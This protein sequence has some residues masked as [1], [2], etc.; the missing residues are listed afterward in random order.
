MNKNSIKILPV[1][2]GVI[3]VTGILYPAISVSAAASFN[4]DPL[5][6]PTLQVVNSTRSGGCTTCWSSSVSANDGDTISFLLYYHN[7]SNETANQTIVRAILPSANSTVLNISGNVSAQN[8][9]AT[10]GNATVNLANSRSITYLPGSVKWYPNRSSSLS[11]LLFGQSGDEIIYSGLNIGNI[12]PGW[13]TQGYVIFSA[14]ISTGSQQQGFT[15][16]VATNQATNITQSS[17]DLNGSVN[18]NNSNTTVWFEYGTTMSLGSTIGNQS[19]GSGNSNINIFNTLSGLQSNTIYYFR[20]VAQNSVGTTQGSILSFTTS[21]GQQGQVPLVTTNSASNNNQN[22]ATL[23]GSVNPNN[24][25]TNIWFEY[26][27]TPSLGSSIGFQSVGSGNSYINITGYLSGLQSNTT[28]YFRA[29]A[30][31]N[32]GT[33]YGSVLNFITQ[34]GGGFGS[35]PIVTTNSASNITPN[36]ATLNGS[37]NPNNSNTTVWFEYGLNNSLGST[38][39]Y[40]SVNSAN[41]TMNITAYLSGIQP[42]NT[43][44]Y[45]IVAQNSYGT[46]YGSLLSFYTTQSGGGFGSAPIVTTNAASS[47]GQAYATLNTSVNPN[48]A[49]AT[50]WFEYG[51]TMSLGY[52]IG[53]QSIGAGNYSQ[54]ISSYISSLQAN[55]TYYFRAVAQNTYGTS[56]GSILSFITQT[57][58]QTGNAPIVSTNSASYIYQNSAL[59][60]GTVNPNYSLTTAWFE[61]GGTNSLGNRTT[62]QS[63]GDGTIASPLSFALTGLNSGINYYY[64]VAAQNSYGTS[65]GNILN[66]TTQTTQAYQPAEPT[67]PT[68]IIQRTA[69]EKVS[70]S[71]AVSLTPAVDNNNPRAG[72]EIAYTVVY[73]NDGKNSVKNAALKI[74]LPKEVNYE[75]SNL[76]PTS[77]DGNNLSFN[78]GTVDSQSQGIISIKVKINNSTKI[79]SALIFNATLNYTDQDDNFQ[80]VNAYLTVIIGQGASITA[81]LIDVIGSLFNNWFFD[82]LLG[83]ILGFGIYHFFIRSKE[84]DLAT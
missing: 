67:Q 12:D 59:L 81:S 18:P 3:L 51:T 74:V 25:N 82:L 57:G 7:T 73:R 5:D 56:Y 39:G 22:S 1:F 20:A 42:N 70:K 71:Q 52:S 10:T 37:V 49:I 2:A 83:L 31:N 69:T 45:R 75:N 35:A 11:P 46:M 29:A 48:G 23:N 54:N 38:V 43:Y 8:A 6:L 32:F 50:V 21:G 17:A 44:Y 80:A 66:L 53:Y 26:G 84:T 60:N 61:W 13:G 55:A 72:E 63:M 78:L 79:G 34:S 62:S 68:V 36:S 15:P 24:S 76:Q 19:I 9:S 41:Y 28:Y 77:I 64:R 14:R 33:A 58:Y 27:Q 40:Q 4:N 65:Y 47:I 16:T 30:Q